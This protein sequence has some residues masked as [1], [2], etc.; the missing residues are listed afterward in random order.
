[1]T[2]LYYIHRIGRVV[3][4]RLLD[5]GYSSTLLW[6]VYCLVFSK[7]TDFISQKKQC[8]I[9]TLLK[10]FNKVHYKFVITHENAKKKLYFPAE[11]SM[12]F[13]LLSDMRSN[14][15]IA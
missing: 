14:I 4:A 10:W 1:M 8:L 7:Y 9:N 15:V 12:K 2:A 5:S 13:T 3:F 11:T 6:L